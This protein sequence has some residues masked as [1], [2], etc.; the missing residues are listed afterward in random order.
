MLKRIPQDQMSSVGV[1]HYV[2]KFVSDLR[3]VDGF[4]Q[5]LRF[6]SRIKQTANDITEIVLKVALNTIKQTIKQTGF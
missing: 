5:I 6:P 3:Q 1:Q 4:L 2:I